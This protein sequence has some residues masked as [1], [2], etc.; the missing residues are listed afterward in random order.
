[1]FAVFFWGG[2]RLFGLGGDTQETGS[3]LVNVGFGPGPGPRKCLSKKKPSLV[4]DLQRALEKSQEEA[5]AAAAIPFDAVM[6]ITYMGAGLGL[7]S[8]SSP[9]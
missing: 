8:P 4:P 5:K 1:M 7:D 9:S 2:S 3:P 6:T